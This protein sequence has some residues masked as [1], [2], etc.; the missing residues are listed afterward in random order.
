MLFSLRFV[1]LAARLSL[2]WYRSRYRTRTCRQNQNLQKQWPMQNQNQT[3]M[4][5]PMQSQMKWQMSMEGQGGSNREEARDCS[6]VSS[7]QQFCQSSHIRG[8]DVGKSRSIIHTQIIQDDSW[9]L[10]N[11]ALTILPKI[12][13][14]EVVVIKCC[15]A[16]AAL[17]SSDFWFSRGR[18]QVQSSAPYLLF[19]TSEH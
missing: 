10:V 15:L 16:E 5:W 13:I 12:S 14:R 9:L 6:T 7:L 8:R 2:S 1:D 4:Q 3:Q 19:A 17:L 11:P 18:K